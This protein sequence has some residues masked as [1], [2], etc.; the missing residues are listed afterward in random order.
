MVKCLVSVFPGIIPE[1]RAFVSQLPVSIPNLRSPKNC[2]IA[3]G[4]A[5][6]AR[7]F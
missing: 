4:F 2:I 1:K 5:K 6:W 3:N 7:G